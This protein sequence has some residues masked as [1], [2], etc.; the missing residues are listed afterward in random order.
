MRAAAKL[1]EDSREEWE[2]D[3]RGRLA[4]QMQSETQRLQEQLLESRETS[5]RNFVAGASA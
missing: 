4:A 1:E 5:E 3:L 2:V